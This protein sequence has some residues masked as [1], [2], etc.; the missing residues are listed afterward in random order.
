M[1][2]SH[3]YRIPGEDFLRIVTEGPRAMGNL[4]TGVAVRLART[5]PTEDLGHA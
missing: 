3:L 1:T 4:R 2:D 5:H